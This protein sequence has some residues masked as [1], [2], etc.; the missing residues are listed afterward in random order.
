[1][2][3]ICGGRVRWVLDVSS[4]G[5][6]VGVGVGEFGAAVV[7]GA[8]TVGAAGAALGAVGFG[9]VGAVRIGARCADWFEGF[10]FGE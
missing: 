7:S 3:S 9:V 6:I 1:M 2:S 10:A 8:G 5:H 4:G